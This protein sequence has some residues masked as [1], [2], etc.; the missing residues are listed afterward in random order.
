MY[1]TRIAVKGWAL[2]V[3]T[4][5][6]LSDWEPTN[7]LTKFPTQSGSYNNREKPTFHQRGGRLNLAIRVWSVIREPL[8]K[9]FVSTYTCNESHGVNVRYKVKSPYEPLHLSNFTIFSSNREGEGPR[10]LGCLCT[11]NCPCDQNTF[12]L[13]F[14]LLTTMQFARTAHYDYSRRLSMPLVLVPVSLKFCSSL[15]PVC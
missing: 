2:R 5:V 11:K 12:Y 14:R 6:G 7:I 1:P 10:E 15:F 8:W 9:R 3:G 4:F 13:Q